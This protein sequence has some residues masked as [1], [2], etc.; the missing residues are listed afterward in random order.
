[1]TSKFTTE[2]TAIFYNLKPLPIQQMLDFD[3]LCARNPSVSAIVHPGRKGFHKAFFGQQ[4][5]LIP[6][7]DSLQEAT[8]KHP[9]A[10]VLIN[11]ASH[12]SA[13]LSSIEALK[14]DSL[15]CLVIVAEG[16]PERQTKELITLA[17]QQRKL[18]I[19]PYTVGGIAAGAFRIAGYAG[20]KI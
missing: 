19:G 5:I 4:E 2:T 15:K 6:V 7:Y 20:G 13:H 14:S 9:H 10:E 1:M 16:I 3:F 17:K 8:K 18:I 12:R 11:F